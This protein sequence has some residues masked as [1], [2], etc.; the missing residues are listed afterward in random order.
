MEILV[1]TSEGSG[2]PRA[3]FMSPSGLIVVFY[4]SFAQ[5]S[6]LWTLFNPWIIPA[7]LSAF[8]F[9]IFYQEAAWID[10]LFEKYLYSCDSYIKRLYTYPLALINTLQPKFCLRVP[11]YSESKSQLP[12][13][14]SKSGKLIFR[15]MFFRAFSYLWIKG[16]PAFQGESYRRP[17]ASGV[18]L[19]K[20]HRRQ[21]RILERSHS[22]LKN[23]HFSSTANSAS[24]VNNQRNS[25]QMTAVC[26]DMNGNRATAFKMES[27]ESLASNGSTR[28]IN[29]APMRQ[30]P[31]LRDVSNWQG[32]VSYPLIPGLPN[33]TVEESELESLPFSALTNCTNENTEPS[34]EINNVASSPPSSVVHIRRNGISWDGLPQFWMK[35]CVGDAIPHNAVKARVEKLCW[36]AWEIAFGTHDGNGSKNDYSKEKSI[37][38]YMS[39]HHHLLRTWSIS[40]LYEVDM[41][42]FYRREFAR[43]MRTSMIHEKPDFEDIAVRAF[44]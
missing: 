4:P 27:Q 5:K 6:A 3:D 32:S 33:M 22:T 8:L 25:F 36:K 7:N 9:P 2:N 30:H 13:F 15:D 28:G 24:S 19:S 44:R 10:E 20:S 14:L 43:N 18:P 31:Q 11:S 1:C 42:R 21:S 16:N 37:Q 35:Q 41:A 12:N 29:S 26:P 39:C 40:D 34:K 23:G 38:C 17:I